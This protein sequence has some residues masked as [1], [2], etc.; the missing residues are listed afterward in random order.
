MAGRNFKLDHEL[1]A[2]SRKTGQQHNVEM[3]RKL[4][5]YATETDS[6][7]DKNLILEQEIVK[8]DRNSK[9]DP[10]KNEVTKKEMVQLVEAGNQ[11]TKK[12][13]LCRK[14]N[15]QLDKSIME[16]QLH[17]TGLSA[18]NHMVKNE[19]SVQARIRN[20]EGDLERKM[21][22]L[23][24]QICVNNKHRETLDNFRT[25][26]EMMD[27]VFM[28]LDTHTMNHKMKIKQ[29]TEQWKKE[30][31][32]QENAK[33]KIEKLH[34][35]ARE[36]E[37]LFQT[38]LTQA[39][40]T[41]RLEAHLNYKKKATD[42]NSN[43][44][45][46]HQITKK[47]LGTKLTTERWKL[48][49]KKVVADMSVHDYKRQ[50]ELLERM[51]IVSNTK[52]VDELVTTFL[53]QEE[54][55]FQWIKDIN[56][57]ANAIE[58]CR[59]RVATMWETIGRIKVHQDTGELVQSQRAETLKSRIKELNT[60]AEK[61][62]A[63]TAG[64][65][66]I[67]THIKPLVVSLYE[68]TAGETVAG[69]GGGANIEGNLLS[70]TE[71]RIIEILA[72]FKNTQAYQNS[73]NCIMKLNGEMKNEIQSLI[74]PVSTPVRTTQPYRYTDVKAPSVRKDEGTNLEEEEYALTYEELKEKIWTTGD[75]N[76]LL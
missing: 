11:Y 40:E 20:M 57:L 38:T 53:S 14:K 12:L 70:Q 54:R 48:Y 9:M 75:N 71:I 25:E 18:P 42:P 63:K 51:Y 30:T 23:N 45:A 66:S 61:Y 60:Q 7:R 72:E 49:E 8:S 27:A 69:E 24:E 22:S 34:Q 33:K 64:Y 50:K 2:Y 13:E 37:E 28:T 19:A 44:P 56:E 39:V 55:Q 76:S 1:L 3:D 10:L 62:E 6:L 43:S 52:T 58:A 67:L 31:C 59:H 73:D 15:E 46:P 17:L 29:L 47:E 36:E 41:L 21:N 35:Q 68:R 5:N 16:L 74:V 32:N 26:R 65:Q 4:N